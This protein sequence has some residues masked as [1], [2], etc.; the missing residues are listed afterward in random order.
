MKSI[1]QR[2]QIN[3]PP[4]ARHRSQAPSQASP[5]PLASP[6]GFAE[7]PLSACQE[8]WIL[9]L[10]FPALLE[11]LIVPISCKAKTW[12]P[13]IDSR[14][15]R[16]CSLVRISY[17][18]VAVIK[19]L[20]QERQLMEEQVDSGLWFLWGKSSR[21]QSGMAASSRHSD[22]GQS[23]NLRALSE[24]QVSEAFTLKAYLH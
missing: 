12:C 23:G 20:R 17:Y 13:C 9:P 7:H 14:L 11:A 3:Q 1:Y 16:A 2:F 10:P 15:Q 4:E 21:R 22:S 24:P 5:L 18:S 8:L 6:H 19:T